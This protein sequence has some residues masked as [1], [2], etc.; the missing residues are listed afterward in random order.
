MQFFFQQEIKESLTYAQYKN[1]H[2]SIASW[3]LNLLV[4]MQEIQDVFQNNTG[5]YRKIKN[6][7]NI[8]DL[9]YMDYD[10]ELEKTA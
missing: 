5:I 6:T 10:N 4:K 7:G 8:H 2:F 3:K 9:C 1:A